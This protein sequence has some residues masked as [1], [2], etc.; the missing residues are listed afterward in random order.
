MIRTSIPEFAGVP[1]ES[2]G[3]LLGRVG[4]VKDT[5]SAIAYLA[6]ASFIN[7]QLLPVDEGLMCSG[8]QQCL[9]KFIIYF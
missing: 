7:G 2:S 4:E 3:Y 6:S 5:S 8:I 9:N 1:K